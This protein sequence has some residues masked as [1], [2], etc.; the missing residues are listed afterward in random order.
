[1]GPPRSPAG[2]AMPHSQG[3]GQGQAASAD[4]QGM[5]LLLLQRAWGSVLSA[6]P[7]QAR[8][9]PQGKVTQ[10][11]YSAAVKPIPL[12]SVNFHHATA[13]GPARWERGDA[14]ILDRLLP[15]DF[16]AMWEQQ[17]LT[18]CISFSNRWNFFLEAF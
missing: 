8:E 15:A 18:L 14:R 5:L 12:E 6:L 2:C 10:E 13:A 16:S 4:R 11:S 7:S 17:L 1:M 9:P 3:T